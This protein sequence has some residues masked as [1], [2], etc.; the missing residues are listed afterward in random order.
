MKAKDVSDARWLLDKL[1]TL[2]KVETVV[3]CNKYPKWSGQL[4]Q[5]DYTDEEIPVAI[6]LA[7]EEFVNKVRDYYRFQ[8]QELG[9][10][11]LPPATTLTKH[12][13][14]VKKEND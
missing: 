11:E 8:L 7:M 5:F 13:L 1:E 3:L 12:Q 9:V 2:N 10:S 14:T 4:I 6:S